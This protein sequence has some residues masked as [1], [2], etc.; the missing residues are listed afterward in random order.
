MCG[1]ND[2]VDF[3]SGNYI[4]AGNV[5]TA[6][7]SDANGN[8]NT[9]TNLGTLSGTISG[10]ISAAFP[11]ALTAGSNYLLRIVSS[12]PAQTIATSSPV[13]IN[14]PPV[15][16][17]CPLNV[18]SNTEAGLCSSVITY[19]T[20]TASGSPAPAI[21]YSKNSGSSFNT[22]VTNVIVTAT[23]T[24]SVTTCNFSVTVTDNQLPTIACPSN[25]NVN[26]ANGL[27]SATI[28]NPGTP[29]TS[30]NCG[31]ASVS[32]NA[33]PSFPVGNTTV[34]WT[35]TDV[36]NNI[37]TCNQL[38]TVTDNQVPVFSGCPA[39]ITTCSNP[40]S[41]TPPSAADNCG[42]SSVMTNHNPGETFP[43]GTTTV[44]YTATDVNG[45]VSNC[46]FN[47]TIGG[48]TYTATPSGPTTFCKPGSVTLTVNPPATSYKWFKNNNAISGATAISYSATATGSYYCQVNG[49]CGVGNSNA[50]SV[51]ANPAPSATVSPAGTVNICAGQ[52]IT[53]SA[54]TGSGLI[55]QWIKGSATIS[56]ATNSTYIATSAGQYKVKVTKSGCSKTSKA[57]KVNV[58]CKDEEFT[59]IS[60]PT[61]FPNP[62]NGQLTIRFGEEH[63]EAIRLIITDLLGRIVHEEI[64]PEGQSEVLLDLGE[65]G[66]GFY[67]LRMIA[68]DAIVVRNLE[69]IK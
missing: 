39:N 25:L 4:A 57:T 53:L 9:P 24:C 69:I 19:S 61:V 47:V 45:K 51:T 40:V 33:A 42:L 21:S 67:V 64:Y 32:N 60:G 14:T 11:A 34:T 37:N 22:G 52:T 2:I 3:S 7:L 26:A 17:S 31:I 12:S 43:P 50:I 48:A 15:I 30:D 54:N 20:A 49:S 59:K 58:T 65:A 18:N 10:T 44:T 56:G 35:V 1:N 38:I 27:C 5:F 6:Q 23:N 8:F 16:T 36:N 66:S 41:W 63:Q 68:G 28:I 62:S 13:T 55:Y 29:L 46:N